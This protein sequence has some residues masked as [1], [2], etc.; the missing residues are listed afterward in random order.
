MLSCVGCEWQLRS[1]GEHD[2]SDVVTIDRYDQLEQ[3]FLEAGDF[4]ALQQ[5]NTDYPI[6]TRMLIEDVL[7]LCPADDPEVKTKLLTFFQDSTLLTISKDVEREFADMSDIEAQLQEAFARLRNLLPG[8]PKPHVYTQIS[9]LD[10][11]IVAGK[12][13][14]G[15]SLDKYLGADYP[16]YLKY[17]Y[18]ERQRSMMTRQFIV[19]DCVG[20][21]LLSLYPLPEADSSHEA[22]EQ[23][24]G[25]IQYI[26]NL[27]MDYPQFDNEQVRKV[28]EYMKKSKN[29]S[30][31]KLL[32]T[33]F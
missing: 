8:I 9:S 3:R 32:Q 18:S 14:L 13:F 22:R 6:E 29:F 5:M 7:Q 20:F 23:H 16:L 1:H 21:Y 27:A 17:G 31:E 19:P 28:E 10:Q 4:S 11:S 26:V 25:K 33:T 30:V 2:G 12:G 24:R 15:I